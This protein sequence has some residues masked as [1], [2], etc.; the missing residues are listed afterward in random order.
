MATK[1]P[2]EPQAPNKLRAARPRPLC[3]KRFLPWIAV[4]RRLVERVEAERSPPAADDQCGKRKSLVTESIVT[5][6]ALAGSTRDTLAETWF[7]GIYEWS[8]TDW[9]TREHKESR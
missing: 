4:V 2:V 1:A 8:S 3:S 7:R 5:A 6:F 9:M